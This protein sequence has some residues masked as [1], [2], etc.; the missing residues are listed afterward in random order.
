ML[1]LTRRIDESIMIGGN[2]EVRVL[3]ITGNQVQLGIVAPDD[4]P[5]YRNEVYERVK[6]ANRAA[7]NSDAHDVLKQLRGHIPDSRKGAKSN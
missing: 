5:L 3:R 2:I 6:D 4:I 1:V 7:T